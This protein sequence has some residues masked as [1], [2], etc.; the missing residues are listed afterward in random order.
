MSVI[1]HAIT[2]GVFTFFSRILG[3]IRECLFSAFL[4]ISSFLDCFF[5]AVRLANT[6]RKIFAEGA[7]NAAFLPKFS[8]V[9]E[10][11][12]QS[13]ADILLSKIFSLMVIVISIFSVIII[14]LYPQ[15]I[16][17]IA[18][19]FK[20]NS[21]K[22]NMTISLGRIMFP[23]LLFVSLT[24]LFCSVSNAIK[25]FAL[26]SIIFSTINVFSIVIVTVCFLL[27]LSI[28][29]SV[30]WLSIGVVCSGIVQV[31]IMWFYVKKQN[32]RVKFTLDF[33]SPEVK[34]ILVKMIPGLIGAGVWQINMLVDTQ[35]CSYLPAGT[36]SML[37]FADKLNQFPLAIIGTAAGVSMLSTL[38]SAINKKD[39]K[40]ANI[41]LQNGILFSILLTLF[42]FVCL[43]TLSQPII[44]SAYERLRFSSEHVILTAI[45]LQGSVI[46][47]PANVLNK[48]FVSVF[49]ANKDTSTPVR[50]AIFIVLL[51]ILFLVLLIPF[52][53]I[54]CVPL[55][56]SLAEVFN[57]FI[58]SFLLFRRYKFQFSKIF[59][60][61]ILIQI[62]SSI[63]LFIEM[64]LICMNFWDPIYGASYMKWI[65]TISFGGVAVVSYIIFITFFLKVF[66]I[67]YDKVWHLK[68]WSVDN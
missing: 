28:E 48:I 55:S 44:S 25:K 65:Y 56:T 33:F 38:A 58:L 39:Y 14:I 41:E 11:K 49:F 40:I 31:I 10:S 27:G 6:C 26:P 24:A 3:F 22:F 63:L 29:K 61:K 21:V 4:G 5:V 13:E 46:G 42:A 37:N 7:F 16:S 67:N 1:R 54:L 51:N 68:T 43:F 59:Y 66:K 52:N 53:Y 36:I 15:V 47:L 8:N 30:F 35:I 62:I 9:L 2:V 19:G 20:G 12:G 57:T 18:S 50:C 60:K 45:A 17:L 23:F 34:E 32:F 64:R